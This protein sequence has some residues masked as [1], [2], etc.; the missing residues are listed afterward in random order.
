MDSKDV[1]TRIRLRISELLKQETEHFRCTGC[2]VGI[3]ND[4][5]T[6]IVHPYSIE[7]LCPECSKENTN[8]LPKM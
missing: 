8:E 7:V 1:I 5:E 6:F 3:N 2:G 4:K